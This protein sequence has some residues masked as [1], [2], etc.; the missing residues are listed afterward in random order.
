MSGVATAAIGAAVI[1]GAISADSSRK[2]ANTQAD[3]IENAANTTKASAA[4][5]RQD[6]LDLYTPALSDYNARMLDLG[7]QVREGNADVMRTLASTGVNVNAMLEQAGADARRAILGSTAQSVGVS[8]QGFDA[9]YTRINALP[10]TEQD[11]A[12]ANMASNIGQ[13]VAQLTGEDPSTIVN[14]LGNNAGF[15][16]TAMGIAKAATGR[17]AAGSI[18]SGGFGAGRDITAQVVQTGPGSESPS[19]TLNMDIT[20]PAINMVQMADGSY[21]PQEAAPGTGFYGAMENLD[22]GERQSLSALAQGTG[23]ARG[24]VMTGRDTSLATLSAAK[25]EA[26]G[27]LQPYTD[28]GRAALDKE[29]AL[30]GAF[31]PEAQQAAIDAYI[32]TPGQKYLREQQ[33][34]TLLR[35]TAAIGGLGGGRV[36]TA[37]QEQAMNIASTNMQQDL[38]NLRSLAMRGQEADTTGANI[39]QAT[40]S[41]AAGIQMSAAQQLA[42]LAEALGTN[43]ANLINM[44]AQQRSDLAMRAGLSLADLEQAIGSAQ[45][46]ALGEFGSKIAATQA[47]SIA[48]V[49]KLGETRATNMLT[50]QQNLAQILANIGIGAGSKISDLQVAGGSAA[51]AGAQQ[52]GQIAAQTINNLG[53]L[54]AYGIGNNATVT[55]ATTSINTVGNVDQFGQ[56]INPMYAGM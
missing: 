52:Q 45:A 21:V 30:T 4:K 8:R 26:F 54:A 41:Q 9:Q 29:A 38:T 36:R 34:Q 43:S 14:D 53:S 51:A 48:D 12:F 32:E 22:T 56:Q 18:T 20:T 19:E 13:R 1:G 16:E 3:A 24:D 5:A 46:G 7:D 11:A 6:V 28:A 23:I 44:T 55:P 39:A 27:R 33:E 35:N 10:P 47:G 50:S 25:N 40:G 49:A 37:L 17:T 2:A 31:G 42:A 15:N